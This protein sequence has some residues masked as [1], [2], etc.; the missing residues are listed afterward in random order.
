MDMPVIHLIGR[1]F[2]QL[3]TEVKGVV[4]VRVIF[5]FQAYHCLYSSK[6]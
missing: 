6:A 2:L 1:S 3:K 5:S 4:R